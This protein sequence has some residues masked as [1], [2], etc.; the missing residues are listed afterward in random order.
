MQFVKKFPIY[1]QVNVEK[2]LPRDFVSERVTLAI[3][4][5]LT[6]YLETTKFDKQFVS[7]LEEALQSKVS[8]KVFSERELNEK[9][10]VS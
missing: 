5:A 9:L 8:L 2:D 6:K 3:L 10:G 7:E 4:D 1:V